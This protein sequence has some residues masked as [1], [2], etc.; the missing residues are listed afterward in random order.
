MVWWKG[1][2]RMTPLYV[3][4]PRVLFNV[5][6]FDE[7]ALGRMCV[8]CGKARL[9]SLLTSWNTVLSTYWGIEVDIGTR[10]I[11]EA[12][13]DEEITPINASSAGRGHRACAFQRVDGICVLCVIDKGG[14]FNNLVDVVARDPLRQKVLRDG[15]RGKLVEPKRRG[16]I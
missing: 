6:R 3:W 2:A 10:V 14:G 13:E 16:K 12:L 7:A 5:Q 9:T 8:T 15:T 4:E 1:A 11:Q